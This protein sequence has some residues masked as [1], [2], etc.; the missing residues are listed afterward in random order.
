MPLKYR[1]ETP[2]KPIPVEALCDFEGDQVSPCPGVPGAPGRLGPDWPL[3]HSLKGL[4]D[5][6]EET[7]PQMFSGACVHLHHWGHS[8]PAPRPPHGPTCCP[9]LLSHQLRGASYSSRCLREGSH[10]PTLESCVQPEP[11][12]ASAILSL[13]RPESHVHP[14]QSEDEGRRL[15]GLGLHGRKRVPRGK[16][17]WVLGW[18]SLS[19]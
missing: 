12:T 18:Q 3:L 6:R 11:I 4:R 9:G 13:A 7:G 1:R 17:R 16:S 15:P 14:E 19:L 5:D 2:L 10:W 8:L